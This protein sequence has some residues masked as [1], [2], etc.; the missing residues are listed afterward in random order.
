MRACVSGTF[1]LKPSKLCARSSPPPLSDLAEPPGSADCH[2]SSF[3]T[4]GLDRSFSEA[5]GWKPRPAASRAGAGG[6]LCLKNRPSLS[7]GRSSS[8]QTGGWRATAQGSGG[9]PWE[10]LPS[11][12]SQRLLHPRGRGNGPGLSYRVGAGWQQRPSWTIPKVSSSHA[13]GHGYL[14]IGTSG[15][16]IRDSQA[17]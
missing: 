9:G 7:R 2:S 16:G 12:P 6:C 13:V 14:G 3:T 17:R 10:S 8:P 5:P 4:E 1:F 11:A 15:P